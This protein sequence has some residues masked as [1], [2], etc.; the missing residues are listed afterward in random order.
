MRAWAAA[1]VRGRMLEVAIAIAVGY[2]AL[3]LADQIARLS[4]GILGQHIGD[5]PFA[6]GTVMDLVSLFDAPYY[7]NFSIAGTIVVYGTVLSSALA[8]GLV[9]LAAVVVVRRRDSAL[10]QCPFCASRIPY[11]STHCAY[12][13][14]G[15]ASGEPA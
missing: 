9:A 1:L 7:L 11:E 8:F 3:D 2:A 10:G 12:C 6:T 14:S 4:T 13:G 15:V 5:D